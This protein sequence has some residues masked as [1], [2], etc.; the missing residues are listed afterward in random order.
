ML[1]CR[2]TGWATD[3]A[4]GAWFILKFISLAQ[5]VPAQYSLT[6]QNHGLQYH[7]FL[8]TIAC[9]CWYIEIFTGIHLLI[10]LRYQYH[11]SP[12]VKASV[13]LMSVHSLTATMPARR[14]RVPSFISPLRF[15]AVLVLVFYVLFCALVCNPVISCMFPFK[16]GVICTKICVAYTTIILFMKIIDNCWTYID[17]DLWKPLPLLRLLIQCNCSKEV[18]GGLIGKSIRSS[19]FDY[20][21]LGLIPSSDYS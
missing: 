19:H 1:D 7:S 18:V 9:S 21:V 3:P 8:N 2:S 5:V 14:P 17:L 4:P 6:G 12:V 20:K 10:R 15:S 11:V 13:Q 16:F